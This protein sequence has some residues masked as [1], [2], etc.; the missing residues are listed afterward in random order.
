MT[1]HQRTQGGG[2]KSQSMLD[3]TLARTA[4]KTRTGTRPWPFSWRPAARL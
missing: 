3:M 1:F 2:T 4:R